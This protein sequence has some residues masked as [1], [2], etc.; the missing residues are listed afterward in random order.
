M[1]QIYSIG[2][3]TRTWE[4]FLQ[5][6]EKVNYSYLADI[7]SKPFSR[8]CPQF[9]KNRMQEQIWDKYIFFWNTLWWMDEDISYE[10][11]IY[12]IEMLAELA[13]KSKVVFMCSERKFKE[14]HRFLKV[15]PELENRG[16]KVIHL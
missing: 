15:T 12:W 2:H 11:F 5:E 3:S 1:K 16:F 8:Y 14:C 4:E 10:R 7:R 9:N 6:L 13:E